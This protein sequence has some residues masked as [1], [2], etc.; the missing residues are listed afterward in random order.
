MLGPLFQKVALSRF[1]HIMGTLNHS[2]LPIIDNLKIT[3]TAVGND[4]ISKAI[5]KIRDSIQ[6]GRGIA[7]PMKD[8][9][10]FTPLVVQMISVGETTG[11]LDD[12]LLKVSRYYDMEVEYGTKHLSTYLEP[13][14][15]LTLGVMVLFFALAI[16][17][18]MWDMTKIA[19]G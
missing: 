7:E 6:E 17:L 4:V 2:G 5:T 13:V 18:P 15:T 9:D 8:I 11:E 19:G 3:A 12:V 1:A 14:L 10:L 16:F